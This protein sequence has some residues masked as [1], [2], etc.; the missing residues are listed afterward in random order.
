MHIVLNCM[1][2]VLIILLC[3]SSA[4]HLVIVGSAVH[5]RLLWQIYSCAHFMTGI[6]A[7]LCFPLHCA[8]CRWLWWCCSASS[9]RPTATQFGYVAQ[10]TDL[11]HGALVAGWQPHNGDQRPH[12]DGGEDD[13]DVLIG[14]PALLARYTRVLPLRVLRENCLPCIAAWLPALAL[15]S[16]C[17]LSFVVL[18]FV[19]QNA[20]IL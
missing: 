17:T 5:F 4:L 14:L 1:Y 3:I 20:L 7:I 11:A 18:T 6:I 8:S 16:C 19:L 15:P 2:Y 9:S 10:P 13:A 12:T